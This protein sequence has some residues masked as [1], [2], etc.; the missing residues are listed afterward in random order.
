MAHGLSA[1]REMFLAEYAA[2]FAAE[3]CTTLVYDHFG[4]GASDGEP[5]QCPMPSIQL[6]GY[7]DAIAWLGSQ[8]TVD[9]D[10]VGIWGSSFSGGEVIILVA[11]SLPIRCAVAQVPALGEGSPA[12]SPAT[13]AVMTEAF[14]A[15][16]AGTVVPAASATPDGLGIMYEDGAYE[17]MTR[18]AATRAPSWRNE[19]DLRAFTE[20]F[21]PIEH[22]AH[23]RVP[24]LLVVARADTLTPPGPATPVAATTPNVEI[25]EIPGGHF[26]AY[27]QGFAASSGA[28]IDWF[29][30]HLNR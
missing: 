5:R 3:G 26:D 14:T 23:A 16:P 30:R 4:F 7:R 25:V 24:L 10:R 12:P 13:I 9:A 2:A 19:I 20:P 28:A 18:T 17:W 1:V 29:R 21:R 8:P 27:E 6:D 15:G 11:E 22:L